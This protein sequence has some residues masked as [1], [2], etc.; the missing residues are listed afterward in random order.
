M[1]S[2]RVDPA[3][4]IV[5]GKK[6][7]AITAKSGNGYIHVRVHRGKFVASAHRM[8]WEHVNGPIPTGMQINHKN[9][10]KADNRIENLELVTPSEN[11]LH[12]YRSGLH[13]AKGALNGRAIGKARKLAAERSTP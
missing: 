7:K 11:C 8:I 13:S 9:G 12:A 3:L 6:G 10:N 5:Y 4:G 2:Y 1:M